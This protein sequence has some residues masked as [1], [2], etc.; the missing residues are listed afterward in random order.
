MLLHNALLVAA[1]FIG[2]R[3][4]SRSKVE[5]RE[6]LL[7][8]RFDSDNWIISHL[9]PLA[10]SKLCSR[11]RMV[12]TNPVPRLAKVEAIYPPKWLVRLSGATP[13]RL[14]VF[15]W[16]ALRMRP[17]IVGGFHL[18]PNGLASV[19]LARLVGAKSLYICTGGPVELIGG[20]IG[21]EGGLFNRMETSDSVVERRLLRAVSACNL[22]ITRGAKAMKFFMS[23]GISANFHVISGGIDA[24]IF[25]PAESEP[26]YDLIFVGRLV[27][28]KRIDLFLRV[29]KQVMQ[30]L[31]TVNAVVVG[32]GPLRKELER[33][34]H[35]LQ[36]NN[37]VKF[38]G[39][40]KNVSDW[41][42]R[43]KI[44]VLTSRS[45]GLSLAMMEAMMCGLP[46][47]VS[48]VGD[49]D[50]LVKEGVNGYLVANRAPQEF[51]ERIVELLTNTRKYE[52]FSCNAHNAALHYRIETV[53]KRWDEILSNL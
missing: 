37:C 47:V 49:L 15:A 11:V 42:R 21:N 46:A 36:I 9:Q 14:L 44:F 16:S 38:V 33:M 20:G 45:E 48:H 7:T 34:A 51:A 10:A 43:S 41:L 29:V 19:I 35:D 52:I 26:C 27:E 24:E 17:D 13:A 25:K 40:Q 5:G 8:G 3:P 30:V 4:R 2:S 28:I 12:S 39:Y 23:K 18:L 32:D 31:P 50:E 6:I 22:I 1:G 53:T